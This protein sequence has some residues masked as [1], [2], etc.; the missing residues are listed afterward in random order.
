MPRRFGRLVG[1]SDHLSY[2][3]YNDTRRRRED[4]GLDPNEVDTVDNASVDRRAGMPSELKGNVP[5]FG[6]IIARIFIFSDRLQRLQHL[7][8]CLL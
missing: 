1:N 7:Q 2:M 4:L 5:I 6:V 3:H 8:R